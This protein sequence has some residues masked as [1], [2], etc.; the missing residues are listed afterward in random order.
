MHGPEIV[1][2]FHCVLSQV[3]LLCSDRPQCCKPSAVDASCIIMKSAND[4][5]DYFFVFPG[6]QF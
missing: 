5:L 2:P 6:E 1:V 3:C 4:L